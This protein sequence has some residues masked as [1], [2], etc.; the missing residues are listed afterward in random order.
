MSVRH[1]AVVFVF[2][3][4]VSAGAA[5]WSA[6]DARINGS[7][8]TIGSGASLLLQ[9]RDG[10]LHEAYYG[11]FDR[12]SVVPIASSTKWLTGA[13]IM[14]LVD[15]GLLSLDDHASKYLPSFSG[16]KADITIR[17]LM[18]HTSGLIPDAPCVGNLSTTLS[19]CVQ[20]IAETPLVATPG[21]ELRYGG[22]SMQ[23][24]GRVAEIAAGRSWP[25]L[26]RDRIAAPLGMTSTD[27]YGLGLTLNPRIAGGARSSLWDY[28]RF[29][30]MILDEGEFEGRRVL[31]RDAVRQMLSDQT[32][33]AVIVET[34]YE[35]YAYLDPAL[36]MNRYGI[37]CWVENPRLTEFSSQGA[38]GFSPWVDRE[39]GI[40]GVLMV[41]DRLA[42]VM[43]LYLDVKSRVR[44]QVPVKLPRRR[45]VRR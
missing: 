18:S 16:D 23:V 32:R 35:H 10:V 14:S 24:A 12:D 6:V 26:F 40:A 4:T 5:D 22:S 31:S 17:Q 38:F 45:G 44:E 11:A 25:V 39:R 42:D 15:D 34:P 27:F 36:P 7:I 1:L 41:F 29:V 2:T 21:T 33:D 30:A 20:Q 19:L 3:C 43:P 28:G 37:G 13:V 8:P 9:S